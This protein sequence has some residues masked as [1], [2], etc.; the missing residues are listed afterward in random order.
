MELIHAQHGVWSSAAGKLNT[1][2]MDSIPTFKSVKDVIQGCKLMGRLI[3]QRQSW[4]NPQHQWT[5]GEL[6][7]FLLSK[8]NDWD[9]LRFTLEIIRLHPAYTYQQSREALDAT[10]IRLSK[11]ELLKIRTTA[12][13]SVII[14]SIRQEQKFGSTV[15][16]SADQ[17]YSAPVNVSNIASTPITEYECQQR[18]DYWANAAGVVRGARNQCYNCGGSGHF[19]TTCLLPFCKFCNRTWPSP[20]TPGYHHNT[21]CPTRN[22]HGQEHAGGR[23]SRIRYPSQYADSRQG[24][25]SFRQYDHQGRMG[26]G[27]HSG[28]D[29]MSSSGNSGHLSYNSNKRKRIQAHPAFTYDPLGMLDSQAYEE[30]QPYE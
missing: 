19:M 14:P 18:A 20:G 6:K 8:M 28:R 11:E 22:M 7:D 10:V 9:E 13:M 5:D 4:N 27:T 15:S 16:S 2:A 21:N 23:G 1:K 17:V 25:G 26:S 12:V 3:Q 24:G 30:T 29:I